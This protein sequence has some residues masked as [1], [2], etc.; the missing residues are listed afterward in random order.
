MTLTFKANGKD[1][2]KEQK[3]KVNRTYVCIITQ[4]AFLT[5]LL[6]TF[7]K[8]LVYVQHPRCY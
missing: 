4:A 7:Y 6:F 8:G 5:A 1:K 3:A 2:K